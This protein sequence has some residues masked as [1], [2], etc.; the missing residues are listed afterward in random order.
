MKAVIFDMDG[1]IVN[2]EAEW[3]SLEGLYFRELAPAWTKEHDERA[4][5]LGVSDLHRFLVKEFEVS[6]TKNEFLDH[7]DFSSGPERSR[8][9]P[10]QR[11]LTC[12]HHVLRAVVRGANWPAMVKLGSFESS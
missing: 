3:K 9:W 11:A 1:V 2:S 7:C 5:G 4:V 12:C 8:A 10:G 6:I